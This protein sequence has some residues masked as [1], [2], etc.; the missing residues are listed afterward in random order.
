MAG[1]TS[2]MSLSKTCV[3]MLHAEGLFHYLCYS[4][5]TTNSTNTRKPLSIHTVAFGRGIMPTVISWMTTWITRF[6]SLTRMVEIAQGIQQTVPQNPLTVNIPSSFTEALDTV[7]GFKNTSASE[8]LTP[9]LIRF[10]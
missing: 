8:D 10:T 5:M 9:N 4:K 6:S 7:R 2:V 1:A 3:A